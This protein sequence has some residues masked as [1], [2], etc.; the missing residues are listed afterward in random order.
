VKGLDLASINAHK[1]ISRRQKFERDWERNL[2]YL[3]PRGQE[4]SFPDA[5][6]GTLT[7]LKHVEEGKG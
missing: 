1:I 7:V 3:I 2:V 4:I 5:W 6:E